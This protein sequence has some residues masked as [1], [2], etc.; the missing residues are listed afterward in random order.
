MNSPVAAATPSLE[1]ATMC[2]LVSRSISWM[3][4]SCWAYCAMTVGTAAFGEKSST[5]MS[6]QSSKSWASTDSMHSL[7]TSTGG[8]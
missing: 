3:R 4:E 5:M 8:S 6:S 1:A 2:P 7:S